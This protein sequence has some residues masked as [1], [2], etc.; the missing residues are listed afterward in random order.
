MKRCIELG[1]GDGYTA[2]WDL[3]VTYIGSSGQEYLLSDKVIVDGR[4]KRDFVL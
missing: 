4:G 2:L 3:P 1:L